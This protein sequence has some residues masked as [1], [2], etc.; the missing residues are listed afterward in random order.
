MWKNSKVEVEERQIAV[1]REK[2]QEVSV[3]SETALGSPKL[4]PKQGR[5]LN[6][7]HPVLLRIHLVASSRNPIPAGLS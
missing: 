5:A 2:R 4:S 3:S 1:E 7:L 6:E